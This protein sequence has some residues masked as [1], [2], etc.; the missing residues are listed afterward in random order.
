[1]ATA[2]VNFALIVVL[3]AWSTLVLAKAQENPK[4][5]IAAQIRRQGYQCE[6]PESAKRDVRASK[7]DEPVWVLRCGNAVYRVRLVP[8]MAAKVERLDDK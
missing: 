4:D 5:V 6:S 7:P 3:T 1:M 8:D 2:F